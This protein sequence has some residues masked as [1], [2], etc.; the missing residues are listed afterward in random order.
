[1]N[2]IVKEI[3]IIFDKEYK[4]LRQKC[5]TYDDLEK[6]IDKLSRD[7]IWGGNVEISNLAKKE[8][9]K[10]LDKEIG[11]LSINKLP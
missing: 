4:T 8:L 6:A 9:T 7:L 11:N 3:D 2:E 10:R 1:M 5:T